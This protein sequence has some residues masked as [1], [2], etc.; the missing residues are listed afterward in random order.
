MSACSNTLRAL[1]RSRIPT[2]KTLLPFLYQT[3]TI[4]QWKP[5]AQPIARRNISRYSRKDDPPTEDIP[6]ENK[7]ELPPALDDIEPAR[8]TTITGS[9]RAAFEKLYRKF[10]TRGSR[11]Q[12]KDHEVEIDAIADEYWE[13]DEE[14]DPSKDLDKIFDDVLKGGP[15]P[16]EW[17]RSGAEQLRSTKPKQNLQTMAEHILKGTQPEETKQ[18]VSKAKRVRETSAKAQKLKEERTAERNRVDALLKS[19][20]TDRELWDILHREVFSQV[21]ALNLDGTSPP[22]SGGRTNAPPTMNPKILFS[23]YPHHLLT[24]LTTLRTY[25]PSSPLPL[26]ILPTVKSLG[27]SSYALGA[28][29]ALYTQLLRTAWLQQSS[30]PLLVTLLTDMHNGAIEFSLDTLHLLD[31][32]IKEFDMAR[33][34]RLGREMQMVYGME[35]FGEGIREV[36][37]WRQIVASR[38]GIEEGRREKGT[39]P[40]PRRRRFVDEPTDMEEHVPLVEGLNGEAQAEQTTPQTTAQGV[41]HDVPTDVEFGFLGE[42]SAELTSNDKIDTESKGDAVSAEQKLQEEAR[43]DMKEEQI[44]TAGKS[45]ATAKTSSGEPVPWTPS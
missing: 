9:E 3:A 41:Q 34:G 14:E 19:A 43:D 12:E 15:K 1:S 35:Q 33:S 16:R 17:N 36:R 5:A 42:D 7:E 18:K 13:P 39:I 27:R 23:N 25:F 37:R 21:R 20:K 38:V 22:T 10:N 40:V 8:K 6:F 28:T 30:Y 2:N 4:Q 29:T 11:Q 24:A 26:S 44:K 31:Q 45:E 32:V